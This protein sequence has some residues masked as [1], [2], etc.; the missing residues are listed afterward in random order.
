MAPLCF[1]P[2]NFHMCLSCICLFLLYFWDPPRNSWLAFSFFEK[3]KSTLQHL[4]PHFKDMLSFPATTFP[5]TSSCSSRSSSC[6]SSSS[7]PC[8]LSTRRRQREEVFPWLHSEGWLIRSRAT[9]W[10]RQK[11][12]SLESWRCGFKKTN[13]F[14]QVFLFVFCA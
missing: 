12:R 3:N 9:C 7:S 2:W 8:C 4:R 6:S 14:F 13:S 10:G 5:W 1:V 11:V